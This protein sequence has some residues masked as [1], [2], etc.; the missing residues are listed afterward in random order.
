MSESFGDVVGMGKPSIVWF[1]N[2]GN[3]SHDDMSL[4]TPIYLVM[5]I[6]PSTTQDRSFF[7]HPYYSK[8]CFITSRKESPFVFLT[9]NNPVLCEKNYQFTEM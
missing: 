9:F 7:W 1:F 4:T 5:L 2:F 6:P 3:N 8:C